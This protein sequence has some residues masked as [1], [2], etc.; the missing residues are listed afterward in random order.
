[1]GWARRLA[2]GSVL[3][4]FSGRCPLGALGGGGSGTFSWVLSV[5]RE[6]RSPWSQRGDCPGAHEAEVWDGA[7][8]AAWG[9]L[10]L[11]P[12]ARPSLLGVG[13]PPR[14]T[15]LPAPPVTAPASGWSHR[16]GK[17]TDGSLMPPTPF[18]YVLADFHQP[19]GRGGGL[20]SGRPSGSGKDGWSLG[21]SGKW[22]GP[23]TSA[24]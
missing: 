21:Q 24:V 19:P 10:A 11:H 14:L 20:L 22:G 15:G 2:G 5:L 9:L 7:P 4:W 23:C 1:M 18:L 13:W 8:Q 12:G 17:R 3:H 6:E 16:P